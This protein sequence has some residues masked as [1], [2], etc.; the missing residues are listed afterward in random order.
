MKIIIKLSLI[1]YFLFNPLYI[2]AEEDSNNSKEIKNIISDKITKWYASLCASKLKDLVN[3][4][5]SKITFLPTS[6]TTL[7]KDINGVNKHF[8]KISEKYKE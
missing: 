8:I 3:L 6:S 2:Y 7:I 5:S 1:I 4:Y